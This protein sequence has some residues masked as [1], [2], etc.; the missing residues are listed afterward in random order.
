MHVRAPHYL[1]F[2]DCVEDEGGSG[3]RWR[4]SL[5]AANGS[6]CLEADDCEPSV[7]GKRLELLAVIR[8]LEALDQPSRVTLVTPSRYVSRG[9]RFGL[10]EW[11]RSDWRWERFGEM[12]RITNHDLWQ[13]LDSALSFHQVECRR[14]RFDAAHVNP[15][16]PAAL[17]RVTRLSASAAVLPSLADR[18]LHPIREGRD[19]TAQLGRQLSIL[20]TQ[21]WSLARN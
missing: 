3:G 9:I 16:Q 5:E 20:L 1:L 4:F 15:P 14:W 17:G 8:G 6:D 10:E 11:R 12:V 18:L 7:G 19:A 21:N 2:T 13:R